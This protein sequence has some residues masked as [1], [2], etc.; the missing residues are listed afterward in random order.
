MLLTAGSHIRKEIAY[1]TNKLFYALRAGS[2]RPCHS[3]FEHGLKAVGDDILQQGELVRKMIVK[4]RPV[5][6][7]AF[8]DVINRDFLECLLTKELIKSSMQQL[9]RSSDARI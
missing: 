3:G 1:R 6:R 7:G 5:Y 8:R 2:N 4:C 9:S